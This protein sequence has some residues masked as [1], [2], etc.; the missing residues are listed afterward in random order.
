VK[1]VN[2]NVE[3]E[4]KEKISS[5]QKT[6]LLSTTYSIFVMHI[7][8]VRVRGDVTGQ[9]SVHF[10]KIFAMF[11]ECIRNRNKIGAFCKWSHILLINALVLSYVTK[12][13]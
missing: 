6:I 13:I 8:N 9:F 3:K 4:M 2:V 1:L 11:T 10:S 5:K 7:E 12:K